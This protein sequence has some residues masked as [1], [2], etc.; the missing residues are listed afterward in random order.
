MV[1]VTSQFSGRKGLSRLSR[2]AQ[3]HAPIPEKFS[4]SRTRARFGELVVDQLYSTPFAC[5]RSAQMVRSDQLDT[6]HLIFVI[7]G[8]IRVRQDGREAVVSAGDVTLLRTNAPFEYAVKDDFDAVYLTISRERLPASTAAQLHLATAGVRRGS[9]VTATLAF[10]RSCLDQELRPADGAPPTL[11][12]ERAII[13][14]ADV[15][16]NVRSSGLPLLRSDEIVVE[17]ARAVIRHGVRSTALNAG[18][19]A[20]ELGIS[21][22]ALY[23]SFQ[24]SGSGLTDHIRFLRIQMIADELLLVGPR[25][26]VAVLARSHGFRSADVCGRAF[27]ARYGQSVGAYWSDHHRPLTRPL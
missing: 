4:A 12:E 9:F 24:N 14:L 16:L 11:P 5:R 13:A 3:F 27:K 1:P 21:R 20:E 23:R 6:V 15:V 25:A 2:E 19:I 22:R 7:V 10:L 8:A 17:R 18:S 26:S